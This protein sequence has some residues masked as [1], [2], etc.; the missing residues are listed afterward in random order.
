MQVRRPPLDFDAARPRWI[1][2]APGYAYQLDAA[3]SMLPYLEPY[4]I[5]VQ[6]LARERL[7]PARDAALI[8]DIELFVQVLQLLHGGQDPA[9]RVAG[10]LEALAR[11]RFAG[12]LSAR[13]AEVVRLLATGM[14]NHEIARQLQLSESTVKVHVHNARRKLGVASRVELA[15]EARNKG[16]I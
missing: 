4:L 8:R 16:L 14:R 9:L 1:P 6:K 11:L 3:S 15:I 10:I 5:K 12:H 7:D 13:E 2:A